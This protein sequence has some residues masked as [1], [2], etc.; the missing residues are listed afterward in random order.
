MLHV[1]YIDVAKVN[2]GVALLN[3]LQVFYLDVTS[4]IRDLDVPC[5]MKQMLQR[6]FSS[7]STDV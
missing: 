7:S 2:L 1:L 4:S 3:L 6:I 5:N